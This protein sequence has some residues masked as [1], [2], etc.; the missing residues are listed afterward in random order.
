MVL[1]DNLCGT[2]VSACG[3][4]PGGP[5]FDSSRAGTNNCVFWIFFVHKNVPWYPRQDE[6]IAPMSMNAI[7]YLY[8]FY[9]FIATDSVFF[10]KSRKTLQYIF[11]LLFVDFLFVS[12]DLYFHYFFNGF[13]NTNK[14]NFRITFITAVKLKSIKIKLPSLKP[15]EYFLYSLITQNCRVMYRHYVTYC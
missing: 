12:V 13:K 7:I 14:A 10:F 1:F 6:L 8:I 5:L 2:V 11:A 3:L 4:R 9:L 15:N